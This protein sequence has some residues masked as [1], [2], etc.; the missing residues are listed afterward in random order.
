MILS[1]AWNPT[2]PSSYDNL[3]HHIIM[4]LVFMQALGELGVWYVMRT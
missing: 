3:F 4:R 1:E 2:N